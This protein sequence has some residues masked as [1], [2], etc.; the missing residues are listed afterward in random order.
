MAMHFDRKIYIAVPSDRDAVRCSVMTAIFNEMIDLLTLGWP[1]TVQGYGRVSPIHNARNAA[2]ADF[3][4]SDC[5]H[6]VCWDDD[7]IPEAGAVSRL[8]KYEKDFVC[9]VTPHKSDKLSFPVRLEQNQR[10]IT[11]DP[12]T[13]LIS[14]GGVPFGLVVLSRQCVTRM[15]EGYP[16]LRYKTG[17][18]PRNSHRLFSFEL[19]LDA[20]GE[21]EERSED[22]MFCKRW[23]DIGGSIWVDAKIGFAH[24]GDKAYTGTLDEWLRANPATKGVYFPIDDAAAQSAA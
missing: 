16:H 3:M 7:V 5:S 8:L 24:I 18:I 9:A 15:F 4:A 2:L 20:K 19:V 13:G 21:I 23:V 14:L 11:V 12:A 22:F 17:H 1:P 6:L 10:R